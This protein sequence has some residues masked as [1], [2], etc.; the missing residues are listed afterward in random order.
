MFCLSLLGLNYHD[1]LREAYRLVRYGGW[2]KVAEPALRWRD[3]NL[4]NSARGLMQVFDRRA[5]CLPGRR[6]KIIGAR[7]RFRSRDFIPGLFQGNS[8]DFIDGL[9]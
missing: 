2:L 9:A 1:Y 5:T 6:D 7:R 4:E 3:G 8:H